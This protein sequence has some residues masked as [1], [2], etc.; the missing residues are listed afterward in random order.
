MTVVSYT[1]SF[2]LRKILFNSRGYHLDE[3]ANLDTIDG[4]LDTLVSGTVP[5]SA[6]PGGTANAITLNFTPDVTYVNGQ[7]I[8]FIAAAANTGAVTVACDGLAAKALK[9]AGGSVMAANVI[10][11]GM[12]VRAIFSTSLDC[13]TLIYPA[14]TSS[15]DNIF[16]SGDSG[17]TSPADAD[18]LTIE[19]SGDVGVSINC[20]AGNIGNLNFGRPLSPSAGRIT[21]N[22]TTEK[23]GLNV[24]G[25][26]RM[27]IDANGN[28]V[29]AGAVAK[30]R[31][32]GMSFVYVQQSYT[33]ATNLPTTGTKIKWGTIR[34]SNGDG[35]YN[36]A[37]GEY[38]APV[39]GNYNISWSCY[40][41]AA[42]GSGNTTLA[43]YTPGTTYLSTDTQCL[44]T[45]DTALGNPT[46]L[47]V[48]FHLNAGDKIAVE[49]T[50]TAATKWKGHFHVQLIMPD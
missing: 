44:G 39:A 16:S 7:L 47:L 42:A 46:G 8:S 36:A 22:H 3:W 18:D 24:G 40:V 41:Y 23:L 34:N 5:F 48:N 14:T 13:F 11:A 12:Y 43:K 21:Y 1:S 29:L 15:F 37:T 26:E 19:N 33:A 4:L 2:R 6:A 9:T 50:G 27:N 20:P 30:I 32:P 31:A 38:T 10:T 25:A 17:V 45:T 35:A 28:I 49:Y